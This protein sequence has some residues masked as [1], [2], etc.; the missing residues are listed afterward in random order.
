ML[1]ISSCESFTLQRTEGS[2]KVACWFGEGQGQIRKM[3]IL[4][5][6]SYSFKGFVGSFITAACMHL[7]ILIH[8]FSLFCQ[9]WLWA[10]VLV[11]AMQGFIWVQVPVAAGMVPSSPWVPGG[12]QAFWNHIRYDRTNRGVSSA[13]RRDAGL[14]SSDWSWNRHSWDTFWIWLLRSFS[15]L[16]TS[17]SLHRGCGGVP[18]FPFPSHLTDFQ[19]LQWW[20]DSLPVLDHRTWM[21]GFW[22]VVAV[23]EVFSSCI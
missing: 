22:R 1:S 23:E 21:N 8:A 6:F 3:V 14:R 18:E 2:Y 13:E 10:V 15:S 5:H 17:A 12:P 16:Q 7:S 11:V 19:T 9:P 4:N 20:H